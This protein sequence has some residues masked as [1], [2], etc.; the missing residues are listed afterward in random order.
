MSKHTFS[1]FTSD[2]RRHP[3]ILTNMHRAAGAR[4]H[5]QGRVRV[6]ECNGVTT[7]TVVAA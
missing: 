3:S 7:V 4:V 1:A 2:I 5:Y 6:T